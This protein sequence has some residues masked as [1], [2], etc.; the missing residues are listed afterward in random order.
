MRVSWTRRSGLAVL[1]ATAVVLQGAGAAHA[2]YNQYGYAPQPQQQAPANYAAQQPWQSYA[3]QASQQPNNAFSAPPAQ[4]S[5]QYTAMAFNA[6]NHHGEGTHLES[7]PAPTAT[8]APCQ[9][10]NCGNPAPAPMADYSDSCGSYGGCNTGASYGGCDSNCSPYSTFGGGIGYGNYAGCYS[11][12]HGAGCL[13][14][15]CCG[16]RPRWF[17]GVYGLLM[18]RDRGPYVPLSFSTPTANAPPY[19]PSDTEVNLEV[20]DADIDYQG[21]VEFRLGHYLGGGAGG[22][23]GCGCGPTCAVEG[24][25][26]GLFEEDG[27]ATVTDLTTDANRL[28]GM[29]DF[30]GLEYSWT[31][32]VADYRPVNDYWDYGPPTE[33]RTAPYDVE[34]RSFQVRSTFSVQNAEINLLSLPTLCGGCGAYGGGGRLMGRARGC[35]MGGYGGCADGCAG[36]CDSCC[37]G[38][39]SCGCASGGCMPR[40]SVTTVIGARFM[41]FDEDFWLRSD[42]ERMDT[43]ALGFLAYNVDCDNTLYGAQLG[44]RGT[45]RLGCTGRFALHCNSNVGLYG[46]HIEVAQWMDMPTGG[47]LR[48]ANNGNDSFYV[49]NEKEDISILG[50]LRLGASYQYSCNCRMYGGWRV[51]GVTGVA[52]TTDQIPSSFNS[53][54]QVAWIHS[55]GSLLIHGLQ[56]GVEYNY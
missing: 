7:V 8:G 6:M 37:G 25:Y 24:V 12:G 40:Y 26:W 44:C 18:E 54:N 17:G 34:I 51:L 16:C 22:G 41:R 55:N 21:G 48:F 13:S 49:E 35:G 10:G 33:D 39:G 20:R 42:F 56:A 31:G 19:Y 47:A 4:Q 45:Y 43:N 38:G 36:G 3:P 14:G 1:A 30:R 29:I 15:A 52:L 32:L 5:P 2:Q 50:E 53:P 11:G 9:T 28:Y 27:F 23:C 46:N